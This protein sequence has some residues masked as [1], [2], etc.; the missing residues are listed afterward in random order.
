MLLC[1]GGILEALCLLLGMG[2]LDLQGWNKR[3]ASEGFSWEGWA[4]KENYVFGS[5]NASTLS[6]SAPR[7]KHTHGDRHSAP[8]RGSD[9]TRCVG[10]P[11]GARQLTKDLSRGS[12]C[13]W[14]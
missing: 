13:R 7:S 12:K 5:S 6:P 3:M 14:P 1:E 11:S 9:S 2:S 8:A 10:E 4:K